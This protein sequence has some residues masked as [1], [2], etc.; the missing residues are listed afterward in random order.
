[1]ESIPKTMEQIEDVNNGTS[2]H[3]T[4]KEEKKE[5]E[6]K[7]DKL[8]CPVCTGNIFHMPHAVCEEC[9]FMPNFTKKD[10]DR[11]I[12]PCCC[13][14]K[15]NCDCAACNSCSKCYK[16]CTAFEDHV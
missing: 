14:I 1:M 4:I 6:S 13:A 15:G 9:L 2:S 12:C 16:I 8:I 5:V 3:E 7:N 11:E 10:F